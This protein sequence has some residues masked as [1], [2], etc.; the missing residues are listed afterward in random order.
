M[1][2]FSTKINAIK[3]KRAQGQLLARQ[4]RLSLN[5]LTL[6]SKHYLSSHPLQATALGLL[7]LFASVKLSKQNHLA[8]FKQAGAVAA[9][10]LKGVSNPAQHTSL[11]G[12]Q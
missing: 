1:L 10:L 4:S 11:S 6:N 5:L 9:P 2:F 7:G 8:T 3:Q 12:G